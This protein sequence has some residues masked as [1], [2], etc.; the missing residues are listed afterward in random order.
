MN[1]YLSRLRKIESGENSDNSSV[2]EL[3]KLTEVPFGGFG[4]S[5]QAENEI[6]SFGIDLQIEMIRTFLFII[7]EPE[8][9]H[10]L[11]IDKCR[12]DPEVLVYFLGRIKQTKEGIYGRHYTTKTTETFR[13]ILFVVFVVN[14][15]EIKK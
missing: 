15:L 12:R 7:E 4:S 11:V 2:S 14:I 8:E 9:D 6:N 1:N 10:H 3:P 5:I 13:A